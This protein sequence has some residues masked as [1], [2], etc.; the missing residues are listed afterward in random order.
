MYEDIFGI[1]FN[2]QNLRALNDDDLENRC[3]ALE[4][5]IILMALIIQIGDNTPLIEILNYKKNWIVF[6]II[7]FII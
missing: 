7:I 1:L 3:L 6:Q 2:F 4:H 5:F